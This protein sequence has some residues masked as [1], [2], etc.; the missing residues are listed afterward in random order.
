MNTILL[1][2]TEEH[3]I[4]LPI[5]HIF[6]DGLVLAGDDSVGGYEIA[7]LASRTGALSGSPEFKER[8]MGFG[9]ALASTEAEWSTENPFD[10]HP[11]ALKVCQ[12]L[13]KLYWNGYEAP[14]V[15]DMTPVSMMALV[16]YPFGEC[17]G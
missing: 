14:D 11:M 12:F 4:E 1:R 6:C 13:K 16:D 8:L 17:D 15:E 2:I 5:V 7:H 3:E 9:K 10:R